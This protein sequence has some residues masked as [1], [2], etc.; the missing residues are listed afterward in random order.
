MS[1]FMSPLLNSE[2]KCGW[3]R[4]ETWELCPR[5]SQNRNFSHV[6]HTNTGHFRSSEMVGR[7]GT[8]SVSESPE[9]YGNMKGR[10]Y[11][12]VLFMT[13]YTL[14]PRTFSF[15][16]MRKKCLRWTHKNQ[17]RQYL[18]HKY[19]RKGTYHKKTM[20]PFH[21]LIYKRG[22]TIVPMKEEYS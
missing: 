8:G 18:S 13:H 12:K 11:Q 10:Q 1:A 3:N 21:I 2:G 14:F 9:G 16:K 20:I 15:I 6:R 17:V 4:H 7:S 5:V 19:N 22:F